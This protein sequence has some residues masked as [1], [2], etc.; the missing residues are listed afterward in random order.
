MISNVFTFLKKKKYS[1]F[2]CVVCH[3]VSMCSL[4]IILLLRKF[5][6]LGSYLS[7][8]Y[9]SCKNAIYVARLVTWFSHNS[10]VNRITRYPSQSLRVCESKMATLGDEDKSSSASSESRSS[11]WYYV[12]VVLWFK[13]I[14]ILVLQKRPNPKLIVH[15]QNSCGIGNKRQQRRRT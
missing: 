3:R 8:V 11:S 13:I 5:R 14:P 10:T 9:C 6:H 4:A 12:Q 2:K 15:E 7:S 1:L